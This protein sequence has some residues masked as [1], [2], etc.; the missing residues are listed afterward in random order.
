MAMQ[1]KSNTTYK[2][3]KRKVEIS[4]DPE[5]VKWPIWFD[6]IATKLLWLVLVIILLCI[7][8]KTDIMKWVKQLLPFLT[9]FVV[10]VVQ[11]SG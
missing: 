4:G 5:N 1:K 2:R 3:D 11:L 6:L 9:L 7:L 10:V 8:P